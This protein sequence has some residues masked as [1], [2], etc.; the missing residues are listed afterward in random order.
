M[1][2]AASG[3]H[4]TESEHTRVA[5]DCEL[6]TTSSTAL[7]SELAIAGALAAP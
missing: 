2:G 7:G 5:L 6:A 3:A 1:E 4:D